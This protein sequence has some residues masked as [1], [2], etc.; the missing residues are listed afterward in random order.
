[1]SRHHLIALTS[2]VL[3]FSLAG[4]GSYDPSSE[5]GSPDADADVEVSREALNLPPQ[6]SPQAGDVTA[7]LVC[8][9]PPGLYENGSCSKLA[10]GVRP[11]E[12]AYALWSD[13]AEKERFIYLP[14]GSKIDTQNPDRWK[15]PVGTR[16]Y[17]TFAVDGRRIE[18]RLIEKVADG[19]GVAS[20]SFGAYAWDAEQRHTTLAPS[21]GVRDALGTS[22]DIPSQAECVRCH[23]LSGDVDVINGFGALQLNH[24]G[25]GVTLRSLLREDLLLNT[26]GSEPNVT[27][28]NS[29]FSGDKLTEGA[30]GYLHANCGHCH[31]GTKPPFGLSLWST[32]G[33]SDERETPTFRTAVCQAL[34]R[35]TPPPYVLRIAPGS[36]QT[37]GIVGR[38]NARGSNAQMPPLGTEQIDPA[39]LAAVSNWIDSLPPDLCDTL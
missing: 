33:T 6:A 17:K 12:P 25:A 26:R 37:S 18:T 39:G 35:W 20:W 31:G 13:G 7:H 27:L 23:S 8:Q 11:Y 16:L 9:G 30:L 2:T 28:D 29:N 19:V 5:D 10:D 34:R 15:F 1:M 24:P 22:H 21:N 38:M 4:C 36:S 3:M 32:V 14:S